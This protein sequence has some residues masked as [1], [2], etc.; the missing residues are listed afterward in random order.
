MHIMLLLLGNDICFHILEGIFIRERIPLVVFG[1]AKVRR[2]HI[3][4]MLSELKL[5]A[6]LQNVHA[7]ATHRERVKGKRDWLLLHQV[8]NIPSH[9]GHT[10]VSAAASF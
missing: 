4:A 1:I 2:I 6:D 5:E 10:P 8:Y 3:S 9:L 7:S